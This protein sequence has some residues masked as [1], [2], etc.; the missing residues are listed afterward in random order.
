[1]KKVVLVCGHSVKKDKNKKGKGNTY[2]CREC[3]GYKEVDIK[4]TK[5]LI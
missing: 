1:M 5:Q 2:F 4:K 3:P